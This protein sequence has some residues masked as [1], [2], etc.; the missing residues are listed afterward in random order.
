MNK[1]IIQ[2]FFFIFKSEILFLEKVLLCS[3]SKVV[4]NQEKKR[5]LIVE[6]SIPEGKIEVQVPLEV[7]STSF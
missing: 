3:I 1:R 4:E 2:Y 6:I 5:I 7:N